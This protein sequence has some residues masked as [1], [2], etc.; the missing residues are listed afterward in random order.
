MLNSLI[1]KSSTRKIA[2]PNHDSE[3]RQFNSTQR[4]S[5]MVWIRPVRRELLTP[6]SG[7]ALAS[8]PAGRHG[9]SIQ[10]RLIERSMHGRQSLLANLSGV[11]L[12]VSIVTNPSGI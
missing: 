10:N 8:R 3:P 1:A 7:F 12:L 4:V 2:P 11:E 6:R 5:A 9:L